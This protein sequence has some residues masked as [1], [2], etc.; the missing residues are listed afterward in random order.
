M[1]LAFGD[2]NSPLIPS[3]IAILKELG[4]EV[5]VVA[6][7]NCKD[8]PQSDLQIIK[9]QCFK[10]RTLRYVVNTLFTFWLIA[11]YRPKLIVVHWASRLYQTLAFL[12]F[13]NKLIVSC[14][15]GDID[16]AQDFRGNKAFWVSL[17][18]RNAAAIT[19]KSD[20]MKSMLLSN[21]AGLDE[22]RV[23]IINW[24]VDDIFF[25]APKNEMIEEIKAKAYTFFCIRSM[26]PFYRK[27]EILN[28]FLRFKEV[29][30]CEAKLI[31]STFAADVGYL[32]KLK[33]I[34]EQSV[35]GRDV[36]FLNIPHDVMPSV[37]ASVDAVVSFAPADGLPQS[38][39][40][41][42][43]AGKLIIASDLDNYKEILNSDNSILCR[44]VDSLQKAFCEAKKTSKKSLLNDKIKEI[45]DSHQQ[46]QKYIKLCASIM[47]KKEKEL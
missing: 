21:V 1:I 6:N 39:M 23:Y 42:L 15:G 12:P 32:R 14:M 29:S 46:S 45:L 30:L 34:A 3:R 35:F 25:S 41:S 33:S 2:V 18:L 7:A 5:I 16:K 11:K 36:V 20:Y 26:Q 38:F 24:G 37:L 27:G 47:H 8:V 43:A 10:N 17:L 9:P 13:S 31:I 28:A 19:V 40:E 44:D 22:R 4:E